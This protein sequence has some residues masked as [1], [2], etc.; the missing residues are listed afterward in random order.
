[1]NKKLVKILTKMAG[2]SIQNAVLIVFTVLVID[3]LIVLMG[4]GIL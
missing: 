4:S 2:W 1:M 3:A